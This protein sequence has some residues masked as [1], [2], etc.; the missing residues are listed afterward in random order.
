[1]PFQAEDIVKALKV[2]NSTPGLT[3]KP[4]ILSYVGDETVDLSLGKATFPGND[5]GENTFLNK[6]V[7][8]EGETFM[9]ALCIFSHL[10]LNCVVQNPL[11]FKET[12]SNTIRVGHFFD[13]MMGW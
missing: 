4:N 3:T 13:S 10:T 2:G 9:G 1:M 8:Q 12:L 6:T 11:T 5:L 7:L